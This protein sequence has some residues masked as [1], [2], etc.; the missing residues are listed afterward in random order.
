MPFRY[1]GQY[2]DEETG[3]YYN[4]FRYYSP[5]SGTYISQDPIGLAGGM[6][7]MYAYVYDTNTQL[8]PLGLIIVYRA[9]NGGQEASA[10]AGNAIQPKDM[11]AAYTIQEHIDNGRLQTQYISTTKKKGTAEFYA[12]PN[13]KRGKI[14]RAL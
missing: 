5:E 11:K 10:L 12:K 2:E 13:P 4:R 1:Q 3:L 6:P 7:N 9:L 8:D 14:K